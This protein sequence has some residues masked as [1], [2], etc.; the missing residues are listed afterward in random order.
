MIMIMATL[1][2]GCKTDDFS[3]RAGNE[4][5]LLRAMTEYPGDG[6][7]DPVTT[8]VGLDAPEPTEEEYAKAEEKAAEEKEA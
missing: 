3:K 1:V 4:E 6:I 5:K 7:Y 8:V 2:T